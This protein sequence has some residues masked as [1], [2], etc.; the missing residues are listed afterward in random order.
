MSGRIPL[1][2]L[3]E[4]D[5]TSCKVIPLNMPSDYLSDD[6]HRHSYYELLFF[7]TGSGSHM[8]DLVQYEIENHSIHFVG[9]GQVHALNRDADTKGYVIAFSKEFLF[10][11]TVD[12][13]LPEQFST[14]NKTA[15]PVIQL[16]DETAAAIEQIVLLAAREYTDTNRLKEK[17]LG[18][19]LS[20]L[21]WKCLSLYTETSN[22]GTHSQEL[23]IRFNELL[24]KMFI[25][26]HKVSEYA[27]LLN[28]SPTQL[29]ENTK[30]ITG[31]TTAELIHQRIILEAKRL[32]VHTVFTSKEIAYHLN[33][34][35][36][37]YFSRFFK[38]NAGV[39]PEEFRKQN[40]WKS[41]S[42]K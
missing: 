15:H 34:T 39:S 41:A 9:P 5:D 32:L 12:S 17:M 4:T 40:N 23:M 22:A 30:K 7:V 2:E 6:V 8:I 27:S 25:E 33:F 13:T 19:Y 11:N 18:S 14:F 3:V 28:V 24:E 37:S 16:D 29:S 36:P 42:L 10:L 20:A 1:H 38:T 26:S 21:L 35:D 31:K